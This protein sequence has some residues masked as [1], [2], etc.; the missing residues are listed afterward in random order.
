VTCI[1]NMAEIRR[2]TNEARGGDPSPGQQAVDM[3][4]TWGWRGLAYQGA[5]E[6]LEQ[7]A[8]KPL[9]APGASKRTVATPL[10]V[11]VLVALSGGSIGV[12]VRPPSF[13]NLSCVT[14]QV[15]WIT[16]PG[17]DYRIATDAEIDQFEREA[18]E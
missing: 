16:C 18:S 13:G 14:S 1:F 2:L 9:P 3:L 7:W 11:G 5:V 17:T 12:V 15:T 8:G 6:L 10:R 4:F